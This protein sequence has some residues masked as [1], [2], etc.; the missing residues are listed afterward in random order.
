MWTSS[1]VTARHEHHLNFNDDDTLLLWVDNFV[2]ASTNKADWD[3]THLDDLILNAR[4][5]FNRLG[6]ATKNVPASILSV[7]TFAKKAGG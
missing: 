7:I 4:E 1:P 3:T 6:S 2:A 5:T